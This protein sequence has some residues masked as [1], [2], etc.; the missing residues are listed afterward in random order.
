VN[1]AQYIDEHVETFKDGVGRAGEA[2]YYLSNLDYSVAG[3]GN[4]DGT[5]IERLD[6]TSGGD[7]VEG[8]PPGPRVRGDVSGDGRIDGR[9]AQTFINVLMGLDTN[10]VHIC[11]ADI[12]VSGGVNLT[13]APLFVECLLAGGC[14]AEVECTRADVNDDGHVDGRDAQTF[15][16]V[17]LGLDTNAVHT[18][19]ADINDSGTV[20]LTDVPLFVQCLLA[21]GCGGG[22]PLCRRG[23]V[24]N[25]GQVTIADVG[26][27]VSVLLAGTGTAQQVCAADLGGPAYTIPG[28]PDGLIDGND[29]QAFL[30]CLLGGQCPPAPPGFAGI[31]LDGDIGS[32]DPPVGDVGWMGDLAWMGERKVVPLTP[33]VAGEPALQPLAGRALPAPGTF[34]MHG[35]PIDVL[36]D[37]LVLQYNRA[38]YYDVKNGRWLQRDPLGY[39]DGKNLYEAFRNNPMRLRDPMGEGT[40]SDALRDLQ[41]LLYRWGTD[42]GIKQTL[43]EQMGVRPMDPFTK[44]ARDQER[45]V[46]GNVGAALETAKPYVARGTGA[47][48]TAGGLV[49]AGT[50]MV[51]IPFTWGASTIIVVH[52][53]DVTQASVRQVASGEFTSTYTYEKIAGAGYPTAAIV[54]DTGISLGSGV[55]GLRMAAEAPGLA[56]KSFSTMS[57][58]ADSQALVAFETAPV[59]S[60]ST[61]SR[62]QAANERVIAIIFDAKPGEVVLGSG[63]SPGAVPGKQLVFPF[64]E[65]EVVAPFS[66]APASA[67]VY[68]VA[69]QAVLPGDLYPGF[70]RAVHFQEANRILLVAMKA[71]PMF[72]KQMEMLIPGVRRQIVG[73]W[74]G[75]SRHPPDYW[76]WHH[77][78]DP[79]VM[80]LVPRPQHTPGSIW[81]DILHP[82]GEGGYSRWGQ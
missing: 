24:N 19:A 52:G 60:A 1:G 54:V 25:D 29:I 44:A 21:G 7:F 81:W 71:D 17:L 64:A 13:D 14:P 69:F 23:D 70:S 76:T 65:A 43:D 12:D 45:I 55:A 74:G 6:Y 80:Q 38:R 28:T 39:T 26:P 2:T 3:T 47:V 27:F 36:A 72:A 79:G 61:F 62:V 58:F 15:I 57:T 51:L 63:I 53:V 42:G 46:I 16:N 78:L 20:N 66:Q 82:G 75:I 9:D 5:V 37:G 18:C 30:D 40:I 33:W 67:R 73:L 32:V 34:A 59:R 22:P 10:A 41:D 8:E 31:L 77:A 49:E 35:C 11:A 50:G 56:V 48:G 68:S 4:A